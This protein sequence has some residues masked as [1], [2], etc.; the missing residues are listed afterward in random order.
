MPDAV[1]TSL[2]QAVDTGSRRRRLFE[3]SRHPLA[4][5]GI[6]IILGLTIWEVAGSKINPI[7]MSYPSA[8]GRA[9]VEMIA[10]GELGRALLLSGQSFVAGYGLAMVI[11]IPLGLVMGRYQPVEHLIDLYVYALYASPTVAFIPLVILWFGLGLKAKIFVVFIMALFPILI[12]TH[13]G[14]KNVNQEWIEL[15][16]A[17]CANGRDMMTEIVWY[18]A[19]PFVMAGLRLAVGRA[20]V[21]MVVAE[22]F[23]AITGLGGII[24]TAGNSFQTARMF[25]PILVL[26]VLGV[27][28]TQLVALAERRM[29]K[30]RTGTRT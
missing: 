24:V 12:N 14:V 13:V 17:F 9:A 16:Q 3:W 10:D 4:A 6:S 25:V 30:W 19:L 11:G 18:A 2:A 23:T 20:I 21:G 29:V 26:M 7:F 22:F 5:R 1:S 27:C 15:G 8:I 28:L